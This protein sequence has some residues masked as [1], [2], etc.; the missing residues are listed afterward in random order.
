M[1]KLSLV[2]LM[3]ALFAIS[4]KETPKVKKE[5]EKIVQPKQAAKDN[6]AS[7]RSQALA[8]LNHR[9]KEDPE[10]YAAVE[11]GYWEYEFVFDG[12]EMSRPGAKAGNWVNFKDDH[13]YDYGKYNI[14]QGK[15]KYHYH[16]GDAKLLMVDDVESVPPQEWDLKLSGNAMVMIGNQLYGN[17]AYQ[18]KLINSVEQPV[19]P[20]AAN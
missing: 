12:K 18:I 15:G 14:F 17:S 10:I 7:L 9:I 2:V 6:V 11:A 5:P 8:I 4:C 3:L 13:T 1:N 19:S 20:R 16:F